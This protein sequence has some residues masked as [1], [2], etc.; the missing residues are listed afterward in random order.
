MFK[1][2]FAVLASL[3]SF[4]VLAQEPLLAEPAQNVETKFTND[5]LKQLITHFSVEDVEEYEKNGFDFNKKDSFGNTPLYYALT[6]NE[7][8]DVAK[9]MIAFGADVNEPSSNGIIPLNVATSKAHELQ[10]QILMMETFGL[11]LQDEE[12]Q[13]TLETKVYS[14]M[15][16]MFKMAEMLITSGADLNKQST[17]GTPLMNA[18]TNAWNVDI[19][20]L[21]VKSGADL[22]KTDENSRTALFYAYASGNTDIVDALIKSG[23]DTTLK[24]IEGKLYNEVETLKTQ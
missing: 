17:L 21:L 9:K 8:L 15:E 24:D 5:D 16:R 1:Y 3:C 19:V 18:V 10:L 4:H 23:A 12:V 11:N 14:E 2:I 20:E 6:Q 13:K 7:N 22:N